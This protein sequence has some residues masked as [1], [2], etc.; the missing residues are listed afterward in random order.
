MLLL[1]G[2]ETQGTPENDFCLHRVN[3]LAS[4]L[5]LSLAAWDFQHS[6]WGLVIAFFPNA[7]LQISKEHRAG[8]VAGS[9]T[10]ARMSHPNSLCCPMTHL[11]GGDGAE[12]EVIQVLGPCSVTVSTESCTLGRVI[13]VLEMVTFWG[14]LA[15][16]VGVQG[17]IREGDNS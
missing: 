15:S 11:R 12:V 16:C 3:P 10:R 6:V 14:F 13:C 17:A 4:G 8:S 1:E 2:A 5:H 7:S 9:E